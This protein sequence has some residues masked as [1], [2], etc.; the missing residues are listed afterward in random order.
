VVPTCMAIEKSVD[1]AYAI[2]NRVFRKV[3][4]KLNEG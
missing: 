2:Y 4:D 3:L 1:L